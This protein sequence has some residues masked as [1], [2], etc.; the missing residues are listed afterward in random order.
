MKTEDG[1][2]R[3]LDAAIPYLLLKHNYIT[4]NEYDKIMK[5]VKVN[6]KNH[7]K[8]IVGKIISVL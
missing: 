5:R 3:A 4:K 7:R 1:S 8:E 6:I 2:Y